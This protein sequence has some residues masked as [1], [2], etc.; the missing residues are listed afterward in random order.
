MMVT[1]TLATAVAFAACEHKQLYPANAPCPSSDWGGGYGAGDPGTSASTG[2]GSSV[3]CDERGCFECDDDGCRP[4]EGACESDG[5]C[6]EGLTCDLERA[7]CVP[8]EPGGCGG[9]PACAPDEACNALA[10]CVPCEDASCVPCE[11]AAECHVP[12]EIC[13]PDFVCAPPPCQWLDETAC[14]TRADCIPVY[15]GTDCK[16]PNGGQCVGGQPGCVCASYGF[17]ACADE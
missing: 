2:S 13:T 16:D 7:T 5:D 3:A 4:I 8:A 12:G 6:P 14:A 15:G 9:G 1:C 11:L 10:L 17:V